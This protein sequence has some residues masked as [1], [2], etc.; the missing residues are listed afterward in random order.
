M[1]FKR[2]AFGV[3][4][5]HVVQQR[6]INLTTYMSHDFLMYLQKINYLS[7]ILLFLMRFHPHYLQLLQNA[8]AFNKVIKIMQFKKIFIESA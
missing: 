4:T 2:D 1:T 7:R 3:Y 6:N 8:I 5:V